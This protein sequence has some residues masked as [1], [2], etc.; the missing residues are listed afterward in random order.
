VLVMPALQLS[1]VRQ[2]I[3]G[4]IF[5]LFF[6]WRKLPLPTYKDLKWIILLAILNFVLSNGLST[7]GVKY[8]PSG[9]GC[10]IAALYP[11]WLV[12]WRVW[13]EKQ[14]PPLTSA[15]GLV[16]GFA[17]IMIIFSDNLGDFFKPDFRFGIILLLV[18]TWSWAAGTI[19]T[20]DKAKSFN[21]YV[22][23][24]YQMFIAGIMLLFVSYFDPNY[25]SISEIPA[26][27]WFAIGYL[28]L[29]GS[30]IAFGCFLY[31]LQNMPTEQAS[32]YAYINPIIALFV[33]W[34][35]GNEPL[36]KVIFFGA[37]VTIV[38]VYLV[39]RGYRK[40]VIP[41]GTQ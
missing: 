18:S 30:I 5:I 2:V 24:G 17:G 10:L 31:S 4:T 32:I 20:K 41:E 15:I 39:N 7:W 16:M 29:F 26:V 36:T 13:G 28:V 3:G 25:K 6:L 35:L 40:E 1:G 9:L 23:I 33:G 22:S 12:L 11:L 37:I 27:S 8:V 19:I 38:G 21:P 14:S 34:W